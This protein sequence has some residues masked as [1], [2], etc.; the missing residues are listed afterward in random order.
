MFRVARHAA[1]VLGFLGLACGEAG[2]AGTGSY[3]WFTELPPAMKAESY[4]YLIGTGDILNVR[5]LGHE[6]MTV[7]E[8]VRSDGR[9]AIPILG[10]IDARGKHP[11][12]LRAE[13]EARL[14]DYIVMPSVLLNVDEPQ[15]TTVIMLGEFARPGAYPLDTDPSLAHAF[16]LGGGLTDFASRDSIFVVRQVPSPLR[17]RFTYTAVTRN[18]GHA[19]AFPLRQGDLIVAE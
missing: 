13:L 14:K 16:A 12:A 9:I 2:C 3:V 11:G 5:V 7:R 6:D 1:V 15:P 17:I 4:E 19:A 10:E 18:I 8:K